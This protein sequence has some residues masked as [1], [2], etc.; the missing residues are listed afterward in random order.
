MGRGSLWASTP[1]TGLLP[2]RAGH[3]PPMF[4]IWIL[5]SKWAG[6]RRTVLNLYGYFTGWNAHWPQ[7]RDADG[8]GAHGFLQG[9]RQRRRQFRRRCQGVGWIADLYGAICGKALYTGDLN[10]DEAVAIGRGV[11]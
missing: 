6:Y 2:R 8:I 5:Q 7:Y 3:K 1:K 9:N 10:L 4:P 11:A